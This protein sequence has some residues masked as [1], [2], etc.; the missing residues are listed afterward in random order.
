[1]MRSEV[2]DPVTGEVRQVVRA[3]D[4]L[5][6]LGREIPDPTPLVI[7]VRSSSESMLDRLRRENLEAIMILAADAVPISD[8][9]PDD[10]YDGP[11]LSGFEVQT[12]GQGAPEAPREALDGAA[13]PQATPAPATPVAGVAPAA[14]G[15]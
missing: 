14:S 1:M 6:E 10:E 12:P 11:P 8:S 4:L 7:P 9:E 13:A 5:D 15:A 2:I 3:R